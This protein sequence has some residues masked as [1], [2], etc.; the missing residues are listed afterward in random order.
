MGWLKA[1]SGFARRQIEPYRPGAE[2]REVVLGEG[3][4]EEGFLLGREA[5][6]VQES[7]LNS[8]FL[9]REFYRYNRRIASAVLQ[10]PMHLGTQRFEV[11]F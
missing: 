6:T 3:S 4:Q 11:V 7:L 5:R 2:T 9:N 8:G 1:S 10:Q